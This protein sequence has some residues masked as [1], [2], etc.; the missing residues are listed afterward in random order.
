MLLNIKNLN[1][2]Y[3]GLPAVRDINLSV[4]HSEIIGIAG[5]SGCGKSTLLRS[6]MMLLKN[7]A[8]VDGGSILFNG[9]ELT[10]AS[11]AELRHLRGK[12]ISMIFQNAALAMDPIKTVGRHFYEIAAAGRQKVS[13]K[14]C[15]QRAVQLMANLRLQEPESILKSYPFELSG[16]MI[17]RI[18]IAMALFHSPSLIMADEP[19]SALDV[20]AQVQ[21][22]KILRRL[23]EELRTAMLVVSHNIGVIA[24]L[25]DKI[26]IMYGGRIVEWGTSREILSDPAHP[27]TQALIAAIPQMDGTIPQAIEGKL[28]YSPATHGNCDFEPRCS[29]VQQVCKSEVPEEQWLS[30]THWML[31]HRQVE[32]GQGHAI[33]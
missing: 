9:K 30:P 33:A 26:G 18:A 32:G 29:C 23:K 8:R 5:E 22:V 25:A 12:E 19:T 24:H 16:G 15:S 31:C 27:Y 21:V 6:V 1:I 17:Q 20:T 7:E 4:G 28:Q 10:T 13:R 2:S 11:Q 14:Q 3:A